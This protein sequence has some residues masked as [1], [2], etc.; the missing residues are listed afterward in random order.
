MGSK[1]LRRIGIRST[2]SGFLTACYPPLKLLLIASLIALCVLSL[3]LVTSAHASYQIALTKEKVN[4]KTAYTLNFLSEDSTEI[5]NVVP[6]NELRKEPMLFRSSEHSRFWVASSSLDSKEWE[7][8]SYSAE[9]G[10]EGV[11]ISLGVPPFLNPK[12][13]NYWLQEKRPLSSNSTS[14]AAI[15]DR[16]S[17]NRY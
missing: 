3:S 6:L 7:A 9:T 13:R 17:R 8:V 5:V 11:H 12:A 10:Q 14:A 16:A 15:P 2:S 1:T 4:R